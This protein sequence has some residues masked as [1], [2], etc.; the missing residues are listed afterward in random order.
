MFSVNK[1][2]ENNFERCIGFLLEMIQI[3][4][5]SG[6]E[7]QLAEVIVRYFEGL[8]CD[9]RKLPI[10]QNITEDPLYCGLNGKGDYKGRYNIEVVF[11]GEENRNGLV[12]NTHMDVVPPPEQNGFSAKRQSGYVFGRGACDAKGQIATVYLAMAALKAAN[13]LPKKNITAHF[14]V[15]EEIGG[16]GSLSLLRKMG[17]YEKA[18]I[19]EPT[20]LKIATAARGAIW[21]KFTFNG[22]SGHSGDAVNTKSALKIAVLAMQ[23]LSGYHE[24]LFEK[25]KNTK[26]FE[27]FL[28]PMPLTFGKLHSGTWPSIVPAQAVLEGVL[29]FL[30]STTTEEVVKEIIEL[31][32]KSEISE[33]VNM[34]FTFKRDGYVLER[35]SDFVLRML[36]SCISNGIDNGLTALPACCDG[37]FY[38]KNGIPTIIFGAGRLSDAHAINESIRESDILKAAKVLCT[39]AE[40]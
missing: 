11:K 14:V 32:I 22:K 2:I 36:D 33:S 18:L 20:D 8:G 29:G 12:I 3:P 9:V 13:Y 16:N 24:N 5:I 23:L 35:D 17:Q 7:E 27:G 34:E 30:P 26:P 15:E 19:M 6:K 38:T 21:F 40:E 4:S 10:E 28:N 39:L 1:Q 31:F 37:W 25:L